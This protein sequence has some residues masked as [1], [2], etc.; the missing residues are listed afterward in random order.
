MV[1]YSII[2]GTGYMSASQVHSVPKTVF[3]VKIKS[4]VP[5]ILHPLVLWT[6]TIPPLEYG[7][8]LVSTTDGDKAKVTFGPNRQNILITSPISTGLE[9]DI[10]SDFNKIISIAQIHHLYALGDQCTERV[11]NAQMHNSLY[12][13]SARKQPAIWDIE[14][15]K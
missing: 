12:P 3:G 15:L 1:L 9:I 11:F 14:E 13:I 7:A 5:H 6:Q 8:L 2:R 10:H 4:F